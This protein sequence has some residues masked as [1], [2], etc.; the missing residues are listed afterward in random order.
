[1]T[2]WTDI[3]DDPN[4][5][6]VSRARLDFLQSIRLAA[7][8][9]DRITFL[10][11]AVAGKRVLD[12]GVVAHTREAIEDPV[13]LH[14]HLRRS[15]AACV[16]VDILPDSVG[17]LQSQGYDVR[18]ADLT[19]GPLG[20]TFDVITAGEV[21]EHLDAP[22]LLLKNCASMLPPG[23]RLIATVPNPWYLNVILKNAFRT[24]LYVD[25]ADHVAWYDPNAMCELGQR[26]GLELCQWGGVRAAG[27]SSLLGRVF[28]RFSPWL[29]RLGFARELF[30]KTMVYM[31]SKS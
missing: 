3:S 13:W 29:I 1:M 17:F 31:F 7:L 24:S 14:A 8:I 2:R 25:S 9:P 27:P 19:Q 30:A 12:V 6:A 18:L 21:I 22:G 11:G 16:G 4:A 23:G 26:A 10:V 20:E 15:A 28:F 5:P